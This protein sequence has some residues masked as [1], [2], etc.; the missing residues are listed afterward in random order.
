MNLDFFLFQKLNYLAGKSIFFDTLFIF[1]AEYL[2]YVLIAFLFLLFFKN[3]KKYKNP[4]PRSGTLFF[5]TAKN[6]QM[7][8]PAFLAAVLAR[9]GIVE[10]VRLL[11]ERQRPFVENNVNLLFSHPAT[12]SFPSGHA[13]FFFG[14]SAAV[15]L[16]NKKAGILFFFASFLISISRVI[17][18]VHW[19]SDIIAGAAI[20]IFSGWL[21]HLFFEKISNKKTGILFKK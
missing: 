11:W 3:S 7:V 9:F 13:A 8:L 6:W 20:G 2:G 4:S 17:S 5:A 14:L 21:I 16:Y 15:Y 10:L 18:G 1:L 12:G 19:P